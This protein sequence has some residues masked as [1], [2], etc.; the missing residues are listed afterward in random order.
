ME[1]VK[2][3][4][5]KKNELSTRLAP[6]KKPEKNFLYQPKSKPEPKA[7]PLFVKLPKESRSKLSK[8]A[9]WIGLASLLSLILF[10]VIVS[11]NSN[12]SFLPFIFLIMSF[13]GIIFSISY[14]IIGKIQEK[15]LR[16][17]YQ[18]NILT[19]WQKQNEDLEKEWDEYTNQYNQ[20]FQEKTAYLS[21]RYSY[22]MKRYESLYYCHRDDCIFIPGETSYA[23]SSKLKEFVFKDFSEM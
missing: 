19:Q 17:E 12:L 20:E 10:V 3:I 2:A 22:A 1:K 11:I 18:E 6:P 4:C 14:F 8:L 21:Q 16:K 15:T 9:P 7:K 13:V 5:Y 23:P